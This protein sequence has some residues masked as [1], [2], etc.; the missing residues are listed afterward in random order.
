[1]L[2][3]YTSLVAARAFSTAAT[4]QTNVAFIGLGCMG[5]FMSK[6]L[7]KAGFAVKGHDISP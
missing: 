2:S 7:L 5:R 4:K 1:M 6:N 3:R